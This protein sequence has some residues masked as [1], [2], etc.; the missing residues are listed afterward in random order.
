MMTDVPAAQETLPF[1]RRLRDWAQTLRTGLRAPR[2]AAHVLAALIVLYGAML[3]LDAFVEKYGALDH[4]RWARVVTRGIAPLAARLRPDAVQW[5]PETRPFVGGD[6]VTY[7]RFAREMKGFYQ[8]HVREPVFLVMVR[9]GLWALDDQD[10]ALSLASGVG[11]TLAI[12]ATYLLGTVLLSP[13]AGLAAALLIAIEYEVIAWA[14]DG[15]RDDMF[16]AMVILSAWAL[17]R[18]RERRSLTFALLAGVILGVAC[19]TRITALSFIVPGAFWIVADAPRGRRRELLKPLAIALGTCVAIFAP[20]LISCAI[21]TG[22]PFIAINY[23]TSYYRHAEGR[24]IPEPMSVAAYLRERLAERPFGTID[25]GFNGLFVQPFIYKWR[26][27]DVWLTGLGEYLQWLALAGLAVLPFFARG[28]LFL[29]LLLSSLV[30]YIFTWNLG[31][32]GE[33]RFTMHAYPFYIAAAAFA[34]MGAIH[35]VREAIRN[36][37]IVSRSRLF[38]LGWRAGIVAATVLLGLF[39]YHWLPWVVTRE[40]IVK[41][42]STSL[43][44][45]PRD[46]AFYRAGWSPPHLEGV[47]VRVSLG[48]RS[49]VHVPL[50]DQRDYAIVV[51]IDPVAPDVQNRVNVL[52]NRHFVA[53]LNLS[54]NPERVGSYRMLVRADM[55]RPGRNELAI[56]PETLVTAASAGP[57]FAWLDPDQRVGVRLWYVRVL[58]ASE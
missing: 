35:V 40:A 20:Y 16:M 32:G 25:V 7:L 30:P 33:W 4:P 39:A 8:S 49:V 31:G 44:T 57:R 5:R 21:E 2:T 48:E 51:R 9:A 53:A 11:S 6:P 56:I 26:R 24:P 23:H 17:M 28:R 10:I 34:A 54:V 27:F 41:G 13:V 36:P 38:S 3:R 50:A 19:L 43:E 18:L 45:G 47:T 55:V 12:V 58:P 52:F 46:R 14:P 29:V 37:A 15:W 42:E 1:D 22:D